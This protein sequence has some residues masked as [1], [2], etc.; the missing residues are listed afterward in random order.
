MIDAVADGLDQHDDD[1]S[2]VGPGVEREDPAQ[3]A[4][5]G[6]GNEL[7]SRALCSSSQVVEARKRADICQSR[8]RGWPGKPVVPRIAFFGREQVHERLAHAAKRPCR[9]RSAE[10]GVGQAGTC[11]EQTPGWPPGIPE[12]LRKPRPCSHGDNLLHKR[13]QHG[14]ADRAA[15][16]LILA[17]TNTTLW[18]RL[19]SERVRKVL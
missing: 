16:L 15:C 18:W 17:A 12:T 6:D 3:V 10:L 13:H 14:T 19:P 5:L 8:S 4:S 7:F 11:F 1:R 2:L 9:G